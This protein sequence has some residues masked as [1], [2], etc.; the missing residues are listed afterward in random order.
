MKSR[1]ISLV[2]VCFFTEKAENL[3]EKLKASNR[4]ILWQKLEDKSVLC[5]WTKE[6]FEKSIPLLFICAA[7]IA[8][9]TV[10]PFVKD[11]FTDSPV[12]VM[13]EEGKFIIPILSGHLGNANEIAF[14]ISRSLKEGPQAV[15]TTGT[16]VNG[17]FSIDNFA[18]INGLRVVNREGIKKISAKILAGEK[19]KVFIENSIQINAKEMPPELIL[20]KNAEENAHAAVTLHELS[21]KDRNRYLINLVPKKYCLGIGCKKGKN[22]NELKD[23]AETTFSGHFHTELRNEVVSISSINLKEEETGLLELSHWLHVPFITYTAEELIKAQGDF[24]ESDFV[25]EI[26]GVPN[27]CER[28]VA[29]TAGKNGL[30]VVKKKAENGMTVSIAEK[31]PLIEKWK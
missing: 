28:A 29:L 16:D 5:E 26:T 9:R 1:T 7:G 19:I 6:S 14:E 3:F 18:K 2:R 8:T 27:V 15:I 17:K 25:K 22:F 31:K 11:K 13:D 21:E 4:E 10:A 20:V 30:I 12:L 23:F 24:S